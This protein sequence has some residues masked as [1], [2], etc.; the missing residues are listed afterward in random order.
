M[1]DLDFHIAQN[2]THIML[3]ISLLSFASEG[4]GAG[5]SL[6]LW[7]RNNFHVQ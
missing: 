1:D 5:I 2:L 7:A 4:R 3:K 6:M